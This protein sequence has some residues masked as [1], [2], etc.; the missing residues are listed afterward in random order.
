[1][2]ILSSA[3]LLAG[4]KGC[5]FNVTES[6]VLRL[7][8][9]YALVA[10][11]S[12]AKFFADMARQ[13]QDVFVTW[14]QEKRDCDKYARFVHTIALTA[15]ALQSKKAAGLAFA[16]LGYVKDGEGGHAINAIVTKLK[17]KTQLKVRT[18]EPQTGEELF[19]SAS[20][21]NSVMFFLF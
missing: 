15:H 11:E 3:Q 20:E 9:A 7:D 8:S 1:M 14:Q 18:F 19:L 5:G 12:A 16:T 13:A 17:G 4:I 10:D 21:R 2:T 6:S